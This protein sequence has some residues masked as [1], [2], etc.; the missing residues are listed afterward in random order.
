VRVSHRVSL[1]VSKVQSWLDERFGVGP[2][3]RSIFLR[4]IPIGLNWWYSLGSAAL[5][6]FVIE[7][8]TGILLAMNYSPT[9]EYAY[10][11]VR[12]ITNEAFLA[13][14]VRYQDA[15]DVCFRILQREILASADGQ[16]ASRLSVTEADL[17]EYRVA[18]APKPAQRRP[19]PPVPAG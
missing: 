13:H 6:V 1:N 2:V 11:S 5:F 18:Q 10:D 19:R 4:H 15:P 16:L 7:A 14:R 8:A 17:E 3:W 12:Y 9:P